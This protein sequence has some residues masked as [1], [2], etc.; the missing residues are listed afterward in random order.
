MRD[1]Q[2]QYHFEKSEEIGEESRRV[3]KLM[4]KIVI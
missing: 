4:E 2:S 1:K 3:A